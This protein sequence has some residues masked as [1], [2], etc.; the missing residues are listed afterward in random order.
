MSKSPSRAAQ[1]GHCALRELSRAR[2]RKDEFLKALAPV[3]NN[4]AVK[5]EIRTIAEAFNRPAAQALPVQEAE[6]TASTV[7]ADQELRAYFSKQNPSGPADDAIRIIRRGWS[8]ARI[9]LCF[10]RSSSSDW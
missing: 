4:P 9:E 1:V 8:I 7:A 3:S 5:I 10:T 2:Q 6:E